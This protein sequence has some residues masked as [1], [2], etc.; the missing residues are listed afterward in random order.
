MTLFDAPSREASCVKRSR[1]NTSLQSLGLFNETQRVEM[2]RALA[3]RLLEQKTNDTER[4]DLLFTL[5]ASRKPTK[6]ERAACSDLLVALQTRYAA[7]EQDARALLSIGNV[8]P[9]VKVK[10]ADLAAWSQLTIT[11]LASDVALLLY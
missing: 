3:A 7:N 10:L 2:A 4:L 1:T 11:V 8:T 9:D 6:Q 5:L